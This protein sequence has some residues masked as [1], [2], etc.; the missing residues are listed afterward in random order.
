M[1]LLSNSTSELEELEGNERGRG[2]A[3]S[4][5]QR[6]PSRSSTFTPLQSGLLTPK[7]EKRIRRDM[8]PTLGYEPKTPTRMT[9][10]RRDEDL[11]SGSSTSMLSRG[12]DDSMTNAKCNDNGIDNDDAWWDDVLEDNETELYLNR[13]SMLRQASSPLANGFTQSA[14]GSK[15]PFASCSFSSLP[16][17]ES[18]RKVPRTASCTS[19]GKHRVLNAQHGEGKYANDGKFENEEEESN[20]PRAFQGQLSRTSTISSLDFG[21]NRALET[22]QGPRLDD[23]SQIISLF[24]PSSPL[25]SCYYNP[26]SSAEISTTPTLKRHRAGKVLG[27]SPE[28]REQTAGLHLARSALA[29]LDTH[30]A[31]L[32]PETLEELVELLDR[33]EL[34]T[35]GVTRGRDV[36]REALKKKEDTIEHLNEQIEVLKGE[37]ESART[38]I[39]GMKVLPTAAVAAA[40]GSPVH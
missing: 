23:P 11:G 22:K 18:P 16:L 13:R 39:N 27:G 4:A 36:T 7:T 14:T 24:Q 6:T 37:L 31:M 17:S 35:Q 30:S 8:P 1:V 28:K 20:E 40:S 3:P 9:G 10:A 19:P 26:P 5:S 15:S 38:L 34:Q 33:Y 25:S 21:P 2:V 32:S 12:S 29:I